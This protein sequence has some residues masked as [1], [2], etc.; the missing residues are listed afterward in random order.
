MNEILLEIIKSLINAIFASAF[1]VFS[2]RSYIEARRKSKEKNHSLDAVVLIDYEQNEI[3]EYI[4]SEAHADRILIFQP[5]NSRYFLGGRPII[6]LIPTNECTR[7]GL[8]RFKDTVDEV[9]VSNWT[10]ALTELKREGILTLSENNNWEGL[11]ESR[12]ALRKRGCNSGVYIYLKKKIYGI[13]KPI[14]ILCIEYRSE[15]PILT[16]E[17]ILSLFA[18]EIQKIRALLSQKIDIKLDI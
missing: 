8:K 16:Q 5:E 2:V 13:E 6:N 10:E 15:N 12:I 9:K 3:I 14:G 18:N 11:G 1:S 17:Q 4:K 7:G